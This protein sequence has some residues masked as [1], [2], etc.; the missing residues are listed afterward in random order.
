MKLIGPGSIALFIYLLYSHP[1][2]AIEEKIYDLN[3]NDTLEAVFQKIGANNKEIKVEEKKSPDRIISLDFN[4][5]QPFT[6][7]DK[8][9]FETIET[10]N[11]T[12]MVNH[13][14]IVADP[15][16][17]RIFHLTTELKVSQLELIKP[18]KSK[19]SLKTIKEILTEMN[20]QKIQLKPQKKSGFKK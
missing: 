18:W 5:P 19:T 1:L 17:G 20:Q 6:L 14:L 2:L 13:N 16:T 4:T 11:Q 15:K 12:D 8:D 7:S 10:G 3:G 9:L